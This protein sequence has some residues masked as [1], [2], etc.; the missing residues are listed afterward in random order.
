MVDA[1]LLTNHVKRFTLARRQK[2]SW[3][4]CNLKFGKIVE[5]AMICFDAQNTSSESLDFNAVNSSLLRGKHARSRSQS[6]V[7]PSQ[8]PIISR[9]AVGMNVGTKGYIV[10]WL[11]VINECDHLRHLSIGVVVDN[12]EVLKTIAQSNDYDF[13]DVE[14]GWSFHCNGFARHKGSCFKYGTHFGKGDTIGVSLNVSKGSLGFSIDGQ[15]FGHA[16]SNE[17]MRLPRHHGYRLA[18][19]CGTGC[20]V[21]ATIIRFSRKRVDSN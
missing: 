16:F 13:A 3:F 17:E 12:E 10:E 11:V 15:Q 2:D 4:L 21:Q 8:V 6:A 14:T 7:S 19:S 18:L 20:G 5:D 1:S 9:S